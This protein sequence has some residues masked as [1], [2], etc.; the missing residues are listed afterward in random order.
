MAAQVSAHTAKLQR[1][2]GAGEVIDE[3]IK[4]ALKE[5]RFVYFPLHR[6]LRKPE[7]T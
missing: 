5:C 6:N 1:A 3:I 7:L 4:V 2:E